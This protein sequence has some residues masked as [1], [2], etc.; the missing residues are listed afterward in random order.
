MLPILVALLDKRRR[1]LSSNQ[2]CAL[3]HDLPAAADFVDWFAA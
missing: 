2:L 3:R 1:Q